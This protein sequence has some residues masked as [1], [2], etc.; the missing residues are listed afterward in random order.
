MSI[1]KIKDEVLRDPITGEAIPDPRNPDKHKTQEVLKITSINVFDIEEIR[2]FEKDGKKHAIIDGEPFDR[3][4]S[5]I[6]KYKSLGGRSSEVHV[7]GNHED[8]IEQCN[9]LKA[10]STRS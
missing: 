7:A 8:L 1:E 4:I 2:P 9:G 3:D 6:H 5:V 10:R